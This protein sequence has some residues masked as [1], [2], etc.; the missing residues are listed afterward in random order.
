[1]GYNVPEKMPKDLEEVDLWIARAY[2]DGVD[3]G[4]SL[5]RKDAVEAFKKF[6]LRTFYRAKGRRRRADQED[7]KVQA[8][9]D[10][11]AR[12]NQKLEDGTLWE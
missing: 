11:W 3:N 5:G 2:S 12:F 10:I 7:P 8:I 6:F 9:N 1:M 4:R